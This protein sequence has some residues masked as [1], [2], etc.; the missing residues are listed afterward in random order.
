MPRCSPR[1]RNNNPAISILADGF[2]TLLSA[3][4]VVGFGFLQ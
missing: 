4:I 3:N 1:P 2:A